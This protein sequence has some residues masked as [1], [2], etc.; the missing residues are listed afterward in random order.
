MR[1]LGTCLSSTLVMLG[2]WLDLIILK[3]FSNLS[4][5]MIQQQKLYRRS[6]HFWQKQNKNQINWPEL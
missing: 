5:S 2:G 3:V 1:H 6:L 4:D